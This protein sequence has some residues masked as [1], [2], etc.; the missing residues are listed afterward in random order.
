MPDFD[1]DFCRH[2]RDGVIAYVR[3]KYGK[4]CVAQII[5]FRLVRRQ[6]PSS[7][8]SAASSTCRC[9]RPTRSPRRS[10]S[11]PENVHL[12]EALATSR[13]LRELAK[14][15]PGDELLDIALKLEGLK[16]HTGVHAAGTVITKEPVVKYTP[17]AKVRSPTCRHA[18]RRRRRRSSACSRSTSSA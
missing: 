11:R 17:L 16:R 15:P 10:R 1:I 7:A 13:E 5:T 3:E 12:H 6:A 4:E 18:V 8:T 14:G 2:R 9:G